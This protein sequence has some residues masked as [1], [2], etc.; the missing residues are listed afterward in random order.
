MRIHSTAAILFTAAIACAA[1]SAAPIHA[2]GGDD[3]EKFFEKAGSA[4]KLEVESGRLAVQ[5]ASNPALRSFGEKMVA[6]HSQADSELQAL[7]SRKGVAIPMAMSSSHQ[8]KLEKLREEKPGKDFDKEFRDLMIDSHKEAVHLF[9]ST[10][11]DSKDAEVKAFAQKMLPT[12]KQTFTR[13]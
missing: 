4:G 11:K 9:E 10:A 2:M 12:L 8:K 13:L 3:T 7:A 5:K 1:F 6:E